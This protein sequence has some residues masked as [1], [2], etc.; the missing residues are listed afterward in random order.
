MCVHCLNS[1]PALAD[2]RQI[3]GSKWTAMQ[4]TLGWRHFH[5]TDRRK[6][7]CSGETLVLLVATCDSSAKLWLNSSVLK[8]R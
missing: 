6:A 7:G 2:I 3:A 1:S 8:S 5:V 4:R